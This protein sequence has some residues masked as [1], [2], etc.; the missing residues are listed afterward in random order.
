MVL[1]LLALLFVVAPLV[2][3]AVIVNVA[4]SIG[5]ANTL[6]LLILISLVGAW[7][8]KREGLGV[9]R[10]IQAA[11]DRGELPS[12]EVA[13][14]ALILLAGAL[15]IAPGFLSDCLAL[16]LLFPPTRALVRAPL[17]RAA[18]RRGRVAVVGRFRGFGTSGAGSAGAAGV[19]DVESWEEPPRP[20]LRGE[21][22]D[23]P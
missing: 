17:M 21:L 20:R 4:G 10:R 14:G 15:M 11:L 19:W 8:A 13:D 2:E 12:R 3:L 1:L 7:L 22:G 5:V 23:R 18:T 6:G 9:L 16:L